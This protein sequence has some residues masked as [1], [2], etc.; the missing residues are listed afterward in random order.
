MPEAGLKTRQA[1]GCSTSDAIRTETKN[2]NS[3][4]TNFMKFAGEYNDPTG[5]YY[6][7]ARQYDTATGRFTKPD[8]A[9][10]SPES[11]ALSSYVYAGDRPTVMVD[12]SGMTFEASDCG[13]IAAQMATSQAD[14]NDDDTAAWLE[15]CAS[16]GSDPKLTRLQLRNARIIWTLARDW[17]LGPG[18]AH[19]MIGAALFESKLGLKPTNP[20]TG[21]AGLFQLL[22]PYTTR[23]VK[24]GGLYDSR[25]NTCSILPNYAAYWSLHKNAG[26][27]QCA[28]VV[29]RAKNVSPSDYAPPNWLPRS[30]KL[31]AVKS[32]PR[33]KPF[34][35]PYFA[36]TRYA[37]PNCQLR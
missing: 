5:L 24:L 22:A 2:Q 15:Y 13:L 37:Y 36:G 4:P 20:D 14:V 6:L 26:V 31:I 35:A 1:F 16:A 3:A 12:P 30:F 32:C 11:P 18:R 8:P 23:A 33:L 10:T 19:E 7:R 29:E 17:G 9:S 27:G 25:A 34:C 21:A 28:F